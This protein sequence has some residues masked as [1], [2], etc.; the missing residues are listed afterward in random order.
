MGTSSI[1]RLESCHRLLLT[2]RIFLS[3]I[4]KSA[5]MDNSISRPN[6]NIDLLATSYLANLRLLGHTPLS[7]LSSSLLSR[8]N[9]IKLSG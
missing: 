7:L 8:K 9:A 6:S 4:D 5:A 3:V 2:L 1:L